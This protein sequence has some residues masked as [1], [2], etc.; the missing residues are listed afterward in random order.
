MKNFTYNNKG[1]EGFTLIELLIVIAIL[2]TL[3]VLALIAIDPLEQLARGRD[4]GKLST[5]A[6]LGHAIE[7]YATG[8]A[9]STT[10]TY[11]AVGSGSATWAHTL[12]SA[13]EISTMPPQSGT[14]Q[15]GTSASTAGSGQ[16]S[17]T[18]CYNTSGSG[19]TQE[20][21]VYARLESKRNASLCT[22]ASAPTPWAVYSTADGR[23]GIVCTGGSAVPAV[24]T[25]SWVN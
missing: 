13:G 19:T 3:A 8:N 21:I 16:I 25:Q 24:G 15:C 22:N 10:A 6:Q 14:V 7:A 5:T 18:W 11:P 1:L 20:A 17:N 2:G 23:G 9:G 4:A 12:M